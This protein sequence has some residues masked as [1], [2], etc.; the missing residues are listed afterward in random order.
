MAITSPEVFP[1]FSNPRISSMIPLVLIF[2]PSKV[3]VG[4]IVWCTLPFTPLKCNALGT[5]FRGQYL[6]RGHL[7]LGRLRI[8]HLLWRKLHLSRM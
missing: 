7:F 4:L 3:L 5:G 2:A 8:V 6:R 1:S